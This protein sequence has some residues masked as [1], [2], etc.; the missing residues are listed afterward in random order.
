MKKLDNVV[1]S[2]TLIL[3]LIFSSSCLAKNKLMSVAFPSETIYYGIVPGGNVGRLS[4][5]IMVVTPSEVA[6]GKY[7]SGAVGVNLSL[8]SWTGS[9][10]VPKI[11]IVSVDKTVDDSHCPG[12]PSSDWSCGSM[13]LGVTLEGD[14]AG[15]PWVAA[16]NVTNTA[17]KGPPYVGP[18]TRSTICPT[19]PIDTYDVSWSPDSIQHN[20]VLSVDATGGT[21]TTVL[22]TYLM[23]SGTLC[24]GSKNDSR[25]AYCRVVAT[26]V[27]ISVLGCSDGIVTA[28]ATA[29]P[30]TDKELHDINVAVNTKNVGSGTA[31]ATCNFQYI[32][33]EL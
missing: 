11:K 14:D 4:Y 22:P 6:Y 31:Q 3:L 24:D 8:V 28:T 13:T 2:L 16:V 26:G 12:M 5:D 17:L 30:V 15:C 27:R 33:E 7:S 18:Y 19:I 1:A 29:H 9:G 25:S 32:I 10:P 20:K 21:V 23:E